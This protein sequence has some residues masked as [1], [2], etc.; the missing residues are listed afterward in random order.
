MLVQMSNI[1][2]YCINAVAEPDITDSYVGTTM[3]V[4]FVIG[5]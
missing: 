1:T 4:S 2:Y 5:I 3:I